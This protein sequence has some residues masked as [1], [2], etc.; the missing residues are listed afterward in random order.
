MKKITMLSM[1]AL[2]AFS[3]YVN[4]ASLELPYSIQLL[5]LNG[6]KQQD[7]SVLSQ[8]P[9]GKH[10]IILQYAKQL[11]DG[12]KTKLFASKPLVMQLE[13]TDPNASYELSHK[14][15]YSVN[16]V[17]KALE[18][19]KMGWELESEGKSYPVTI[20]T[21]YG[22]GFAPFTNIE[23]AIKA[24]NKQSGLILTSMGTKDIT[25][26]VVTVDQKT[27]KL[28]VEGDPVT[29]LKLWYTK[30]S[31]EEQKEFRRWMIDQE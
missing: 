29:Q 20:E 27:G 3:S 30:A 25:D 21:M 2:I 28:E 9:E 17:E 12:S 4:A 13:V 6:K 5:A 31:K 19:N 16:T 18:K 11:K 10:Q 24:H 23:K 22:S 26:A 14:A 1:S 8:L 7:K 15:F